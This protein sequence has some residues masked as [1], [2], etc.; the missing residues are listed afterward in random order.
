MSHADLQQLHSTL[1]RAQHFVRKA[2][3]DQVSAGRF[4]PVCSTGL[5]IPVRNILWLIDEGDRQLASGEIDFRERF[6]DDLAL[7]CLLS[8]MVARYIDGHPMEGN[9]EDSWALLAFLVCYDAV[10]GVNLAPLMQ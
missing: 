2:G 10:I 8:R 4:T 3:L 9:V 6:D 5:S 7:M 1:K